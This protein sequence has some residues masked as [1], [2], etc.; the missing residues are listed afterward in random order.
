[1]NPCRVLPRLVGPS[2]GSAGMVVGITLIPTMIQSRVQLER[3]EYSVVVFFLG[4]RSVT[5]Q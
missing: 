1:M 3:V 4:T 5:V 2:L